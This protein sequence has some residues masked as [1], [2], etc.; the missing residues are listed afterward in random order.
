MQFSFV[1]VSNLVVWFRFQTFINGLLWNDLSLR[2][3]NRIE[4]LLIASVTWNVMPESNNHICASSALNRT[5]LL[6]ELSGERIYLDGVAKMRFTSVLY[7]SNMEEPPF[8][9]VFL[10]LF[11]LIGRWSCQ[12]CHPSLAWMTYWS[13][14]CRRFPSLWGGLTVMRV[15]WFLHQNLSFGRQVWPTRG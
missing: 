10:P 11:F 14:S 5:S 8:R 3:P 13:G 9:S 6:K 15:R 1:Q 7:G 12:P 2:L 4:L